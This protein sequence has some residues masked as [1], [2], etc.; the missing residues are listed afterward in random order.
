MGP[1]MG[2]GEGGNFGSGGEAP[3]D[4]CNIFPSG[5]LYQPDDVAPAGVAVF[6]PCNT[7][8]WDPICI[9]GGGIEK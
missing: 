6:Q 3:G 7:N 1:K 4:V 8:C 5:I 2:G 9:T